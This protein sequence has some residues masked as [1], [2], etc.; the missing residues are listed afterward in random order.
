MNDPSV[1]SG[2]IPGIPVIWEHLKKNPVVVTLQALVIAVVAFN[3]LWPR[4]GSGLDGVRQELAQL[5]DRVSLL[6]LTENDDTLRRELS[7]L[8]NR[9]ENLSTRQN[10]CCSASADGNRVQGIDVRLTSL[11]GRVGFHEYDGNGIRQQLSELRTR[12]D[13]LNQRPFIAPLPQSPNMS[14]DNGIRSIERRV[15]RLEEKV[16]RLAS[17]HQALSAVSSS[18]DEN[19]DSA[20]LKDLDERLS[21]TQGEI[22]QIESDLRT[23]LLNQ[24][25]RIH[26]MEIVHDSDTVRNSASRRRFCGNPEI[27]Q[28]WE[29][30]PPQKVREYTPSTIRDIREITVVRVCVHVNAD[31]TVA[32]VEEEA[33]LGESL[34]PLLIKEAK[35][36][37]AR[38]SYQPA[39][40]DGKPVPWRIIIKVIFKPSP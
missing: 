9:F 3:Y 40:L 23:E 30:S 16:E 7:Q 35:I 31:G 37:A 22:V 11:E 36:T 39:I 13:N 33:G 8:E 10:E 20:V 21:R 2:P 18:R 28:D 14:T 27:R 1:P 6:P 19:A 29:F 4:H 24:E 34:S 5:Q 38:S 17:E 12:F 32:N 15:D 26:I 25:K